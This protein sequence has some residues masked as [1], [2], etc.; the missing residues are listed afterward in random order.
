VRKFT[1]IS[2]GPGH[3]T[4]T[5]LTP[6]IYP[7]RFARLAYIRLRA[8]AATA[9][10]RPTDRWH[11]D[12]DQANELTRRRG[13]ARERIRGEHK[14]NRTKS[15]DA[16]VGELRATEGVIGTHGGFKIDEEKGAKMEQRR[17]W[18][19]DASTERAKVRRIFHA[20]Q[21]AKRFATL[22][23][24]LREFTQCQSGRGR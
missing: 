12:E 11:H 2:H 13:A 23:N 8:F 3:R 10:N 1:L 19:I 7:S 21:S 5:T 22:R 4:S 6:T 9:V 16:V 24:V 18:T 20:V 17:F 14:R 15:D